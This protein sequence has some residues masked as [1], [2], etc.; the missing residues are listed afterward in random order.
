[1]NLLSGPCESTWKLVY[2]CMCIWMWM[3]NMLICHVHVCVCMCRLSGPCEST[4]KLAYTCICMWMSIHEHVL[5]WTY[6]H[7]TYICLWV[8]VKAK[9]AVRK[10][11][12]ALIWIHKP[13]YDMCLYIP[14]SS[15]DKWAIFLVTFVALIWKDGSVVVVVV[16]INIL[17]CY[18]VWVE[19]A[20][21]IINI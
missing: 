20:L 6:L 3:Y 18:A 5:M 1:M 15:V 8:Y 7:I 12:K 19:N 9:R 16:F 17:N 4:W 21:S 13:T 2:A 10:H 11:R 14:S